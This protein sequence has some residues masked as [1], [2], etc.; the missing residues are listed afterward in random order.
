[1]KSIAVVLGLIVVSIAAIIIVDA[2][3]Q[4]LHREAPNAARRN[5]A[6]STEA[7][8]SRDVINASMAD[9]DA[10]MQ[11]HYGSSESYRRVSNIAEWTNFGLTTII[12]L[13][14]G[15]LGQATPG[16]ALPAHGSKA[17]AALN[18]TMNDAIN[19]LN[20]FFPNREVGTLLFFRMLGGLSLLRFLPGW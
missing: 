9:A 1:M 14:A 11:S 19:R 2:S 12:T 16:A 8:L 13:I 5:I 3:S 7:P 15:F 17:W 18:L 10:A 20:T 6:S 4:E